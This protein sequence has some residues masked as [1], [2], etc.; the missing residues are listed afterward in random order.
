MPC[1]LS[2]VGV[3]G[4]TFLGDSGLAVTG[5]D[6][7]EEERAGG[8]VMILGLDCTCSCLLGILVKTLA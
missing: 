3:R 2:L 1:R 8:E 4:S 5:G 7:L 6:A